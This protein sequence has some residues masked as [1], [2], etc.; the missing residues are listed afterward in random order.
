MDSPYGLVSR[1]AFPSKKRIVELLR[2]ELAKQ[3][4]Q[5]PAEI[6]LGTQFYYFGL[7]SLHAA[8][9]AERLGSTH[10]LVFSPTLFWE[11]PTIDALASH[12]AGERVVAPQRGL[13][14]ATPRSEDEPIA[15]IG[16]A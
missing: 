13:E 11:H 5:A 12:L 7:S 9:L 14:D 2:Q 4:R 15:I 16:M 6:D 1:G 10:G 8:Q 3:L